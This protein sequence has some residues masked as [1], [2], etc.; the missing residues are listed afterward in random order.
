MKA[1]INMQAVA[2]ETQRIRL[3]NKDNLQ[4]EYDSDKAIG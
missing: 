4:F 1:R 3:S 2:I